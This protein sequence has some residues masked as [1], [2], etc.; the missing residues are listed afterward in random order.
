MIVPII[1]GALFKNNINKAT[2]GLTNKL[3]ESGLT[4]H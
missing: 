3:S 4:E 2:A 1:I